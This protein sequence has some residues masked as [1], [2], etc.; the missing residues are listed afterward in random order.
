M[1]PCAAD[2]FP[3]SKGTSGS[4]ADRIVNTHGVLCTRFAMLPVDGLR[5]CDEER[6]VEK[7][8]RIG[9]RMDIEVES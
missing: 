1:R 4:V 5:A 6:K 2:T 9:K 8:S 3:K 7:V